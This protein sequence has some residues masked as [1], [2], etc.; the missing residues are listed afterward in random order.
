[1]AST[2]DIVEAMEV[3][4]L[5]AMFVFTIAMALTAFIMAWE[6][7]VLSIGGWAE[8]SEA[9]KRESLEDPGYVHVPMR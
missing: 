3:N 8:R 2:T 6:I 4:G 9:R 7:V 5:M 1:M